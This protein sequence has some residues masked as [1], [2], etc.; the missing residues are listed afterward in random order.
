[1]NYRDIDCQ[2]TGKVIKGSMGSVSGWYIAN[3]STGWRYVKFY[4]KATA[5]ASTDTPL[6]TLG[7]PPGSA[8]NVSLR[9][10]IESKTLPFVNGLGIRGT[11][12]VADNDTGAPTTN[13]LVVNIFFQ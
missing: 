5:P 9:T 7:I 2:P 1:M 11:T 6:M 12:G 4:D 8:A 13:D 3:I 10:L